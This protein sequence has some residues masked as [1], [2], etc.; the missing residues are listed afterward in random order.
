MTATCTPILQKGYLQV[1]TLHQIHYEVYGNPTGIP[2]LYLHGGPGGGFSD[3]SKRFF[4]PEQYKVILFDQRGSAKSK[5]FGCIENNTTGDLIEDINKLTAYLGIDKFAIFGGSWG[6]TLALAYA[7]QYPEKVLGLVLRGIFL[8]NKKS[9]DHYLRGGIKTYFPEAWGRFESLVPSKYRHKVA[10]YYLEQ[11]LSTDKT[12]SE[13]FAFEW[14]YYESSIAKQEIAP[15]QVIENVLSFAYHSL[16]IME[17]HYLLN[18]CFLPENF[19]LNEAH[20]LAELPISII[21]GR[22]DIICPPIFA[23]QLQQQIKTS[24]LFI[25]NAGHSASEIAIENKL[26]EELQYLARSNKLG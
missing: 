21:Q 4:D 6:S 3:K 7:I 16:S 26:K 23:Y 14:A 25:V 13:K 15:E 18:G 12:I 11:M 10:E 22:Y 8:G 17:A 1:S 19:I 20:T 24:R 5:P 2:I 9:I